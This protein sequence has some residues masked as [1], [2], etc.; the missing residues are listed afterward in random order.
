MWQ[1]EP[2]HKRQLDSLFPSPTLA[3]RHPSI[4]PLSLTLISNLS[5]PALLSLLSSIHQPCWP[6]QVITHCDD[7]CVALISLIIV[8]I[9]NLVLC[10]D[11]VILLRL[12]PTSS[13]ECEHV[14]DTSVPVADI[15]AAPLFNLSQLTICFLVFT[16]NHLHSFD[17]P[18]LLSTFY[19]T[20]DHGLKSPSCG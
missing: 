3:V 12:Y 15:N 14:S 4:I 8:V 18:P 17:N 5:L 7:G 20:C 2:S 9:L 11:L 13:I 19:G 10:R 1:R 6:A 16:S